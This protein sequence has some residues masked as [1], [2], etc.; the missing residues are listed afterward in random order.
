MRAALIVAL[1]MTMLTGVAYADPGPIARP[2]FAAIRD[3]LIY[4]DAEPDIQV[5]GIFPWAVQIGHAT[6]DAVPP[7]A[8]GLNIVALTHV[9][10]SGSHDVVAHMGHANASTPTARVWAQ[11]LIARSERAAQGATLVG[12][13]IDVMPGAPVGSQSGGLLLNAI[14][15]EIPVGIQLGSGSGG[16]WGNGIVLNGIKGAGIAVQKGQP[17]RAGI[18]LT[19]GSY[20]DAGLILGNQ[21]G[22]AALWINGK[23]YVNFKEVTVGEPDS[24][25]EGFRCLRVTN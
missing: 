10:S 4:R 2:P 1:A 20:T 11:N 23:W 9:Q 7:D 19:Q 25:G 5:G 12:L 24:C 16:K 18:D 14:G 21:S 17:M 3:A 22:G 8:D 15:H 13:E 6:A